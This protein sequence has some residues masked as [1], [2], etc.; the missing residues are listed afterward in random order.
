MKHIILVA[1]VDY[2]FKGVDFRR[3]CDNRVTRLLRANTAKEDMTFH[4]Y[5]IRKGEIVTHEVTY[6]GSKKLDKV[7]RA[8]PYREVT[9]ASYEVVVEDGKTHHY[10]KDGQTN[11]MSVLDVYRAVQR[12]G[13]EAAHTLLELSFFSH[14]WMGGP[15]LVNSHDD[16]Q[17]MGPTQPAPSLLPPGVRDPDDK[18]PRAPKDFV[19]PTMDAGARQSFQNAFY[20]DGYIWIWGCAF[21]R[22]VHEL[23]HKMERHPRY[24]DAGLTDDVIFTFTNLRTEHIDLIE[25]WLGLS[26][27]DRSRI[28]I[29]FGALRHLF[30]L[31]TRASYTHHIA[32]TARVKT[33]GAVMGTYS[34]YDTGS[35]PLMN[36]HSGF[37]RH[38]RFYETYLGFAFDPEGRRYGEHR[39][40]FSCPAPL[41]RRA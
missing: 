19:P 32:R 23:L 35:L 33:Y 6:A 30:C 21:P 31:V 9:R 24:R 28:E 40:D 15:I 34:E 26:F 17:V 41:P 18:D 7:S 37:A 12:V 27:P 16:G 8:T 4:I 2:E 3:F 1:G 20:R 38:I 10:F 25:E 14:A 22:V 5:D 39:P 11:I 36:V 29:A 13:V